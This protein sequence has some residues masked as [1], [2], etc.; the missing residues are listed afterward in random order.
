MLFKKYVNKN[1]NLGVNMKKIIFYSLLFCAS[2]LF[3][4][5][6]IN[7]SKI[8][9][10]SKNLSQ[11][12]RFNLNILNENFGNKFDFS[13]SKQDKKIK[14]EQD[15]IKIL[16]HHE[17]PHG[18]LADYIIKK[19]SNNKISKSLYVDFDFLKKIIAIAK[20]PEKAREMAQKIG[21]PYAALYNSEH[22]KKA[23]E[24]AE[25]LTG[26]FVG[27]NQSEAL[28]FMLSQGFGKD[29]LLVSAA[30]KYNCVDAAKILLKY[31]HNIEE[32][33]PLAFY[34]PLHVAA[35]NKNKE[36]ILF[37]LSEGADINAKALFGRTPLDIIKKK[38][39]V[40]S[41]EEFIQLC[42]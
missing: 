5:R 31:G 3:S 22:A 8:L 13:T 15:I 7:L 30:A 18:Y 20:E 37:L 21:E 16:N 27:Y 36:M 2:N 34:T 12:N 33:A 39:K 9:K 25:I 24:L 35:I 38:F 4:M 26:E 29:Y 28:E 11:Q 32:N 42:N 14:S 6:F 19:N 40:N 41:L 23:K 17:N 1:L 10:N